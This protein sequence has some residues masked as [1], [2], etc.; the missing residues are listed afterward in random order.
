M[1]MRHD[2]TKPMFLYLPLMSIQSPHVG[3]APRRFRHLYDSSST[4]GFESSDQMREALLLT[5][6]YAVHKVGTLSQAKR[7]KK[8]VTSKGL[9]SLRSK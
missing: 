6:D 9:Q 2:K 1:I 3:N 7:I 5:V 4:S 8:R